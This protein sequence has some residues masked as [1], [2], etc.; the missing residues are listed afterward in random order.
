M[1]NTGRAAE[2]T[3]PAG[4]VARR[5]GLLL[6]GTRSKDVVDAHVAICAHRLGQA[7][8]TSE[9]EDVA[10]LAPSVPTKRM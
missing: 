10:R 5:I 7:V 3:E 4:C 9:P 1:I 6:A 2:L 8:V